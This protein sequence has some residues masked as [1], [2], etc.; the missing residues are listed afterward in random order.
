MIRMFLS[1]ISK[2]FDISELRVYAL[3]QHKSELCQDDYFYLDKEDNI[4]KMY[5]D[6]GKK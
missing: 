3:D 6:T 4:T 1:S 2:N 5:P